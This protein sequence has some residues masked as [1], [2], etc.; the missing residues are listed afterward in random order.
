M[1]EDRV[2]DHFHT[3]RSNSPFHPR[4]TFILFA[5]SP[6][7]RKICADLLNSRMLRFNFCPSILPPLCTYRKQSEFKKRGEGDGRLHVFPRTTK[8]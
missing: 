2:F 7:I 3:Y 5:N 8:R 1:T 6:H 4:F